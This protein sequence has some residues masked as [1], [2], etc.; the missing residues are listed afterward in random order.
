[1]S[2]QR[3]T[4]PPS[5]ESEFQQQ[6]DLCA[7]L[8]LTL[9][10]LQGVE[11]LVKSCV[12]LVFK[13]VNGDALT[14][15]RNPKSRKKTLG[16]FLTLIREKSTIDPTFDQVLANF[17]ERRNVFI[18]DLL[19]NKLFSLSSEGGRYHI[20]LF[21]ERL[22]SEMDIVGKFMLG[23]LMVWADPEK[24]HD[25][26]R[27]RVQFA[28]GSCFGEAEQIFAPHVAKLIVPKQ[29]EPQK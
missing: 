8:G 16:Q 3:L 17:L 29:K 4:Q 9:V 22:R 13:D 11:K 21:V 18:H 24:F 26:T 23:A 1:M 12:E 5:A 2:D 6:K 10:E 27:V 19:G 20:R 28:E 25:K 15:L 7:L 14:D